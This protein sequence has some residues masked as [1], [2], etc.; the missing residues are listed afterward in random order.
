MV[1]MVR[2]L[3][4]LF[5]SELWLEQHIAKLTSTCFHHVSAHAGPCYSRLWDHSYSCLSVCDQSTWPYHQLVFQVN[6]CLVAVDTECSGQAEHC[7]NL[8]MT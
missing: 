2:C 7:S 6:S 1:S 5:H 8:L 4:V 3:D